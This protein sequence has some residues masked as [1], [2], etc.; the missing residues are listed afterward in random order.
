M[1]T[2]NELVRGLDRGDAGLRFVD[3]QEHYVSFAE[4]GD[5][6]CGNAR[7][8]AGLVSPGDRVAM[9]VHTDVE[10]VVTAL[11]LMALGAI[12]MSVKPPR[13]RD[14]API[15]RIVDR[16]DVRFCAG[17][18]VEPPPLPT[19]RWDP[20]ARS[21]DRAIIEDVPAET[22][23]FVQFS[24]GSMGSPKAVPVRHESLVDNT[25]AIARIDGRN[26]ESIGGCVVPL[27]HDMG[28]LGLL[29]CFELQHAGNVCTTR[30][31][32]HRPISFL[33]SMPRCDTIAL[34]DFLL[35]YLAR[36]LRTR[37]KRAP[38]GLMGRFHTIF[39]GAEP[40]RRDTIADLIDAAAAH[41]FTPSALVFAYGLAEAT[42]I[43][44]ARR[45]D[46]LE[47]AFV[48]VQGRSVANV[49][50]PVEG[51]EVDVGPTVRLRGPSVFDGYLD[52][53]PLPD[54]WHDTGDVGF[55]QEGDLFVEGRGD[56]M[57]IINGENLFPVDLEDVALR[58]PGVRECVVM[59]ERDGYCMFVVPGSGFS[60]D[61]LTR[62]VTTA[63]GAAPSAIVPGMA[64]DIPRTT[65][66]KPQRRVL[67][68]R[69]RGAR[70]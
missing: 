69:I 5:L 14:D 12:P 66:G 34:P 54:G 17:D 43:A 32:L 55:E 59:S 36:A 41:G 26:S 21:S 1:T 53:L 38:V 52:G 31:F 11:A 61:A 19:L 8:F 60:S 35:R 15:R 45:F 28:W 18:T 27:C 7:R 64:G 46:D 30:R 10:H 22:V 16:F 47:N 2:L 67:L 56:D 20:T 42:L 58:V 68:E 6:I 51:M 50:Q 13:S 25:R 62:E 23:A 4:L 57:I 37:A 40:I 24:S 39:C 29:S 49:G 3:R 65:S 70:R 9:H 44:S 48:D 63:F 33:S